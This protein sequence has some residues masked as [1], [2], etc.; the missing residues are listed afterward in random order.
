MKQQTA[1]L[2]QHC[3]AAFPSL[4]WEESHPPAFQRAIAKTHG[5][6]VMLEKSTFTWEYQS[7]CFAHYR[8]IYATPACS[9]PGEAIAM[10]RAW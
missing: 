9:S 6:D 3:E 2:K 1:T 10:M 8:E 7:R 5:L 4:K